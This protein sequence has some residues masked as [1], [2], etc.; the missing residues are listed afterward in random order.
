MGFRVYRGPGRT[1]FNQA[2]VNG[3]IIRGV[4]VGGA[5][6]RGIGLATSAGN[7]RKSEF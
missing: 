4:G 2:R 5:M 1:S 7:L 6:D 3:F